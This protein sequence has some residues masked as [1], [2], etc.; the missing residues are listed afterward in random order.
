[1]PAIVMDGKALAHELEAKLAQRVTALKQ[2]LQLT[3]MLATILVGGDPASATYVK[4]KGNACRRI[5]MDS[6]PITLTELIPILLEKGCLE[7]RG[8]T[9]TPNPLHKFYDINKYCAYHR[10]NGHATDSCWNLKHIVEDL[11]EA[12]EI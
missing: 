8:P 10:G 12:S 5:G 2:K 3:P 6:L 4:M 9:P 1:M 11:I 7:L